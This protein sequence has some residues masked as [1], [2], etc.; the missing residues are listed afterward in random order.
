MPTIELT[1]EQADELMSVLLDQIQYLTEKGRK[2][3]PVEEI[4]CQHLRHT[5]SEIHHL[6][7]IA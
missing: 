7:E 3:D 4:E 2:S 5:L 6:L 1:Q